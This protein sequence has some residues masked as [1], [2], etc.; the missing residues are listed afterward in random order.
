MPPTLPEL[1]INRCEPAFVDRFIP[2]SYPSKIAEPCAPSVR[3]PTGRFSINIELAEPTFSGKC[4][5]TRHE[6]RIILGDDSLF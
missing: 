2:G 3:H 4:R 6:G 5:Q 1:I